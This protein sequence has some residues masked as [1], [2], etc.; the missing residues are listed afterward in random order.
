MTSYAKRIVAMVGATMLAQLITIGFSPVLT[1]LYSPDDFGV[2]TLFISFIGIFGP[3]CALNIELT[4]QREKVESEVKKIFE[5]GC[6]V[7]LVLTT[8]CAFLFWIVIRFDLFGFGVFETWHVLL[9]FVALFSVAL[10]GLA[11][12]MLIRMARFKAINKVTLM[13]SV[14][15]S[16]VQ[17][18][19]GLWSGGFTFLLVGEVMGRLLGNWNMYIQF[20]EG[21]SF[22]RGFKTYWQTLVRLS[23]YPLFVAPST[24]VNTSAVMLPAIMV[25]GFYGIEAAGLYG[26]VMRSIDVPV[27]VIGGSVADVFYEKASR[28]SGGLTTFVLKHVAVLGVIAL[29]GAVLGVFLARDSF[30]LIF[31]AEWSRAGEF[32]VFLAP[33]FVLQL[34][35]YPVTRVLHLI[36]RERYKLL[37]DLVALM[38]AIV[39]FLLGSLLNWNV[40]HTL[41]MFSCSRAVAY[42]IM[43]VMILEFVRREDAKV[44]DSEIN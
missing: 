36:G 23:N 33:H 21:I 1:R 40:E 42:G 29:A 43:M 3:A 26:L 11:R 16:A 27:T 5:L 7:S 44:C 31:G 32:V 37:Y 22:S 17:G 39:P 13:R 25:N 4:L 8:I 10:F 9:M 15:R 35:V 19:G 6:Y 24:L 2:F 41:L 38:A 18:I 12:Y 34:A 30:A 28:L 14:V 20:R